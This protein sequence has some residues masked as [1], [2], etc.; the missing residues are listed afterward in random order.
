M[1]GQAVQQTSYIVMGLPKEET[2]RSHTMRPQR[3]LYW[4]P[5]ATFRQLADFA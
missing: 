4:Q 5:N 3:K 1:I 2:L